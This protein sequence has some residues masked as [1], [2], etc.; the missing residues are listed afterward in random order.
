MHFGGVVIITCGF[1]FTEREGSAQGHLNLSFG[2]V[3]NYQEKSTKIENVTEVGGLIIQTHTDCTMCFP[4]AYACVFGA[5]QP[6]GNCNCS[7]FFF[8]LQQITSKLIERK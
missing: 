1:K 4:H 8:F 2:I 7:F 3:G 6:F 5:T